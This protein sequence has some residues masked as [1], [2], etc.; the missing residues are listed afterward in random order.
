MRT[1]PCSLSANNF[2]HSAYVTFLKL[3]CTMI[4]LMYSEISF[5]N[6]SLIFESAMAW[7]NS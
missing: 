2:S 5:S 3:G 6:A 4:L 7:A 1:E